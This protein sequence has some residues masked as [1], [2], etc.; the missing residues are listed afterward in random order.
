MS[1]PTTEVLIVGAGPTGLMLACDLHRREIPFRI[2]D[3][4]ECPSSNSR[5]VNIQA[6]TLEA[7]DDIGVLERCFEHG[8]LTRTVRTYRDNSLA[9]SY[10]L[11]LEPTN[12]IPYPYLLILEQHVTEQILTEYLARH[13]VSVERGVELRRLTVEPDQVK[14]QL[15][16]PDG[17]VHL[18]SSYIVGCDGAHSTVRGLSGI[19]LDARQA[20]VVYRLA[21]VEM[22]WSCPH[23]EI[24]RFPHE[25]REFLAIPLP[26]KRRYRLSLWESS[27]EN[28]SSEEMDYGTLDKPP[29]VEGLKE[30]L[31]ELFPGPVE[32]LNARSVMSYRT[33]LGMAQTM[34]KGR[35]LL[36]GD[37]A[38]LTPQCT[39]QGMNLGLQDAYNLGWKVAL[40]VKGDAPQELLESYKVEREKVAGDILREAGADP[41]SLGRAT[42]FES[43]EALDEWSQL[44]LH[45]RTSPLSL[46]SSEYGVQ[47]GDRAPDGELAVDGDV[48]HLYEVMDGLS[49][50]LL[51]FS[52]RD[53]PDLESFLDLVE[54]LYAPMVEVH[55]V[56][57]G[58]NACTDVS[59]RLHRAYG[60]DHGDLVLIRP[61]RFIGARGSVA[62][63]KAV[64]EHLAGYLIPRA[65]S[66]DVGRRLS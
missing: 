3:R 46:P 60:A 37:S 10:A 6:R 66:A 21:D 31:T 17:D 47:A 11:N 38:H 45:Y 44:R 41:S 52:D 4:L 23:D 43:K 33:G 36:A 15:R 54:E 62:E 25:D 29:S 22:K 5:A 48:T 50:H 9:Q 7:F 12:E 13:G 1:Q 14:S 55:L 18:R 32:L 59:R 64:L 53:D 24:V 28:S 63:S 57:L 19:E 51:A 58:P 40:V 39:S 2:I 42:H 20:A 30:L 34:Q 27:T 26:G 8:L 61:D 65:S 16:T 56:G 49:H 35:V